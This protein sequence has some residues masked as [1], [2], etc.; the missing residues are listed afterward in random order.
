MTKTTQATRSHLLHHAILNP[1]SRISP[2]SY[3]KHIKDSIDCQFCQFSSA[4]F[5]SLVHCDTLVLPI[6]TS[7]PFLSTFQLHSH[8]SALH[9]LPAHHA[10]CTYSTDPF[11]ICETCNPPSLLGLVVSYGSG[12]YWF[13]QTARLLG[14]VSCRIIGDVTYSNGTL[15]RKDPFTD[16][17][18]AAEGM[19][20]KQQEREKYVSIFSLILGLHY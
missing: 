6:D 14:C 16:R 17:E 12:R 7:P 5:S 8:S 1:S 9:C 2:S 15:Y 13:S 19:Y 4:Q 18:A 20:I 10:V 11:C 3:P